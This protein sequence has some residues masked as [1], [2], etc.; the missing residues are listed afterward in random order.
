MKNIEQLR[1]SGHIIFECISGSKSYGLDSKNSDTD[2][3]GVFIHPKK[4]FY[5][6]DHIDQINDETND[7]VFYELKKFISLLEKNNPNI[8]ELLF[9]PDFCIIQKNSLFDLI[10]AEYFLSKL[11]KNTFVNYAF[12]QIKKAHGLNK[13]ILNPMEK[14]RK[15]ILDFCHIYKNNTSIPLKV[16]LEKENFNIQYFGLVKLPH[17]KGCYNLFYDTDSSYKGICTENANELR[18]SSVPKDHTPIGMLYYNQEGYSSYCK[19]YKEYWSWVQKRN[20]HRYL[21]T[22]SHGKN[23]DA[24]NMMHTFRLLSMAKEIAMEHKIEVYRKNDSSYLLDIKKGIYN[25]D[26]LIQKAKQLKEELLFSFD[27]STLQE[28]PNKT[29]INHLVYTIRNNFYHSQS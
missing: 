24:K 29:I 21:N 12:T 15:S 14:E 3:R 5:S 4:D 2:I 22:I 19:Q 7:I 10:K 11:C 20:E 17:M 27:K 6:L 13:K 25:Y 16:F 9:V 1:A 28:K 26:Y 23:Y 8:L 18:L